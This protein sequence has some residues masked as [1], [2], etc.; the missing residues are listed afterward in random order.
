MHT[1]SLILVCLL[2]ALSLLTGCY[3][4]GVRPQ[5]SAP[6]EEPRTLTRHS[7][8]WGFGQ[9][10]PIEPD[11]KGNGMSEVRSSTNLGYTL[12]TVATIGIWVPADI[13]WTCAKDRAVLETNMQ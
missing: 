6:A 2:F 13:E 4:Y 10:P 12:I 1:R 5:N 8:F 9:S 11:C 3:H 7:F